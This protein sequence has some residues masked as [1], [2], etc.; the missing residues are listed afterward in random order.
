MHY[1]ITITFSQAKDGFNCFKNRLDKHSAM[2]IELQWI[3]ETGHHNTLVYRSLSGMAPAYLVAD[4][5]MSSEEGRRQ[6]RSADSRTCVI[7]RTYRNFGDRCFTA[8]GPRLRF[9]LSCP[10][11]RTVSAPWVITWDILI[12]IIKFDILTFNLHTSRFWCLNVTDLGHGGT[13]TVSESGRS[14][15]P[16]RRLLY[17]GLRRHRSKHVQDTGELERWVSHTGVS[18]R[19]RTLSVRCHRQQDWP[20]QPSSKCCELE[21]L[22]Y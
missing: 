10:T 8:A 22:I 6:L 3:A 13:R 2:T 11:F 17:P 16:R 7:R 14:V 18:T 5:Q 12:I 4:C 21:Y 15:L 20:Q 19:C 1:N 9:L